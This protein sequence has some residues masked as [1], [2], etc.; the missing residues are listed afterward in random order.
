MC[1]TLVPSSVVITLLWCFGYGA[2]CSPHHCASHS[3]T[4]FGQWILLGGTHVASHSPH[5]I[6]F[7]SHS[8][9]LLPSKCLPMMVSTS[10]SF[11]KSPVHTQVQPI[12]RHHQSAF[13]HLTSHHMAQWVSNVDV[14]LATHNITIAF[15]C[16]PL[17]TLPQW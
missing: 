5:A 1:V 15:T 11:G 12:N 10:K 16:F 2:C 6:H 9:L 14:T 8:T 13:Q 17:P 7:T 4:T 3:H